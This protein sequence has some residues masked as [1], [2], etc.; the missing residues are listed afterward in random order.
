MV[1][2]TDEVKVPLERKP[3]ENTDPID[4]EACKDS[5]GNWTKWV[6]ARCTPEQLEAYEQLQKLLKEDEHYEELK[7]AEITTNHLL[8]VLSGSEFKV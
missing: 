1:E 2:A 5:E 4:D 7:L 6:V 8:R 3:M